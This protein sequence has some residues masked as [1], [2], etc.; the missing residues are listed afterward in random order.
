MYVSC[1]AFAHKITGRSTSIKSPT[2]VKSCSCVRFPYHLSLE[3]SPLA[4]LINPCGR[5]VGS[6]IHQFRKRF[7]CLPQESLLNRASLPIAPSPLLPSR[8]PPS[9]MSLHLV[10]P[11]QPSNRKSSAATQPANG[12][13]NPHPNPTPLDSGAQTALSQRSRHHLDN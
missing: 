4:P 11:A 10:S 2:F 13:P 3:N 12:F 7:L 9:L 5:S 6:Q 8:K 1:I